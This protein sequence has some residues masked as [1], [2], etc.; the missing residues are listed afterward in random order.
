[1]TAV[2]HLDRFVRG[3]FFQIVVGTMIVFAVI[4]IPYVFVVPGHDDGAEA[5][6]IAR[7][8]VAGHGFSFEAWDAWL[9]STLCKEAAERGVYTPTAWADPVFPYVFAGLLSTVGDYATPKILRVLGVLAFL[10]TGILVAATARRLAGP[11]AGLIALGFLLV[12]TRNFATAVNPSTLAAGLI[13]LIIFLWISRFRDITAKRALTV[14]GLLGAAILLWSSTMIFVPVLAVL[15]LLTQGV[16]RKTVSYAAILMVTAAAI[17][18]PWTVRNY[19]MFDE[20]IPVRNGLGYLSF[21]ATAGVGSTY[22]PAEAT[23]E[24]PPPWQS[25]GPF[26]AIDR[27]TFESNDDVRRE[28]E[29]WR[30]DVM[31]DEIGSPI[32]QMTEAS[33]DQWLF[34]Q[35]VAFILK[36]P[37][38]AFMLAAAKVNA[39]MTLIEFSI[40]HMG[41]LIMVA[42]LASYFG[43]VAGTMLAIER[44]PL[45]VPVLMV[46]VFL[47]PFA[48][49]SPYY[50]RYRQPIEPA[51]AILVGVSIVIVLTKLAETDFGRRVTAGLAGKGAKSQI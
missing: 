20:F 49:I 21:M 50:Y 17:V 44:L 22:L 45:V 28:V 33:R 38:A 27:I 7:A 42:S 36:N 39:F 12:V 2:Q 19:M 47:A 35:T 32:A 30:S 6:T 15:L 43:L 37:G 41:L 9:C 31:D 13:A 18:S 3:R 10:G 51:L 29:D 46:W 4:A 25:D 48:V 11:W 1:M 8:I 16:S 40:P 14:G 24:R 23:Y 26:D 34:D 5:E